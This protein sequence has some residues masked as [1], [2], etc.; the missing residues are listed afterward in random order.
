ML[1]PKSGCERCIGYVSGNFS[2]VPSTLCLIALGFD[3]TS[4]EM[5]VYAT[6]VVHTYLTHVYSH[7]SSTTLT[8]GL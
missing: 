4:L 5:F 2:V 6:A 8:V 1:A 7:P 3:G